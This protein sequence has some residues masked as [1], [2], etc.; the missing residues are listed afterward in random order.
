MHSAPRG[1]QSRHVASVGPELQTTPDVAVSL[2][3]ISCHLFDSFYPHLFIGPIRG[4]LVL[5]LS[6]PRPQKM[7]EGRAVSGQG[8]L[9]RLLLVPLSVISSSLRVHSARPLKQR[10]L[11]TLIKFSIKP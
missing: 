7:L 2:S 4:A 8:P 10:I 9:G 5:Q 3:S 1:G 6:W 11:G